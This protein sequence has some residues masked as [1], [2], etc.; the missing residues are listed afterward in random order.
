VIVWTII[1]MLPVRWSAKA[2][3]RS[4]ATLVSSFG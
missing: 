1:D 3:K 4:S 2:R